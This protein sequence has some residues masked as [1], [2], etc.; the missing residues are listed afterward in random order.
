MF[1]PQNVIKELSNVMKVVRRMIVRKSLQGQHN[2]LN[3]IFNIL[4]EWDHL[5]VILD[6]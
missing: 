5:K 4:R 6:I 1:A 3:T 2:I